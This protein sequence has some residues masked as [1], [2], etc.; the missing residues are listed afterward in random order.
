[1]NDKIIFIGE[2]PVKSSPS[3]EL[4]RVFSRKGYNVSYLENLDLNNTFLFLKSI[5]GAKALIV[6]DYS[7]CLF[8]LRQLF[9]AS[10]LGVPVIKWW[11]GSD[12]FNLI[13]SYRFRSYYKYYNSLYNVAVAPH[14]VDELKDLGISATFIPS[15]VYDKVLPEDYNFVKNILVYLPT[16]RKNFYGLDIIEPLIQK[17]PE[18]KFV[19][20]A[21]DSHY[22]SRYNNVISLGWINGLKKVWPNVG[23]LLRITKHDGLPRM[24]ISALMRKKYVIYSWPLPGC[25]LANNFESCSHYIKVFMN[26]STPNNSGPS[27]VKE[28]YGDISPEERYLTLINSLYSKRFDFIK[29]VNNFKMMLLIYKGVRSYK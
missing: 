10:L 22:L 20:V 8:R 15:V 12:V 26:L 11:V 9:L 18:I 29:F 17:F 21:D 27:A 1:M 13:H 23:C 16:D 7:F 28:I 24:I 3:L 4:G 14:L 6:V 2:K 19:V 5:K 25:W